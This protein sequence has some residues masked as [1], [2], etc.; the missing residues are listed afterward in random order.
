M[1]VS[2]LVPQTE[3]LLCTRTCGLRSTFFCWSQLPAFRFTLMGGTSV[4]TI[5]IEF[6][7]EDECV[8]L[9]AK[10][11]DGEVLLEDWICD[12]DDWYWHFPDKL[13]ELLNL[14]EG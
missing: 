1:A 9:V 8:F 11:E 2:K 6:R 12:G 4:H 5:V 14:E 10:S 3:V 7:K 13:R